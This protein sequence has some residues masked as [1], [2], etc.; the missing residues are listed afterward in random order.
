M[1]VCLVSSLKYPF[2]L[3]DA[4]PWC[5]ARNHSHKVWLGRACLLQGDHSHHCFVT[6][7][8]SIFPYM[9]KCAWNWW[10][11][12]VC[13]GLLWKETKV[14]EWNIHFQ[15]S[16]ARCQC[17]LRASVCSTALL[18]H[19]TA[20]LSTEPG[21]TEWNRDGGFQ[22]CMEG[23]WACGCV[24]SRGF[25]SRGPLWGK[26]GCQ[27]ISK[28]QLLHSVLLYIGEYVWDS[29]LEVLQRR[30][31]FYWKFLFILLSCF[32]FFLKKTSWYINVCG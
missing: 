8:G 3:C 27:W 28:V 22:F 15:Y 32:T 13:I 7:T 23:G 11:G 9:L 14:Q 18:W 29:K 26:G 30:M 16:L 6:G 10:R 5:V 4:H 2:A 1:T 24:N 12:E 21:S 17:Y 20:D 19:F 25:D 31:T